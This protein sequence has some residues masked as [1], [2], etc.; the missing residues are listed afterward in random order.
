MESLYAA[1]FCIRSDQTVFISRLRSIL[2][3]FVVVHNR[4]MIKNNAT[5]GRYNRMM[6][7]NMVTSY[8]TAFLA[9][10]YMK[11]HVLVISLFK[12]F[13]AVMSSLKAAL[14]KNNVLLIAVIIL[15]R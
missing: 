7:L 4:M 9:L 12:F 5:V 14:S 13:I 2:S 6:L 15:E 1:I 11:G 8:A 10:A 3:L